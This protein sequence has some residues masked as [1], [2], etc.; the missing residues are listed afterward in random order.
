MPARSVGRRR[1]VV[2]VDAGGA[3]RVDVGGAVGGVG[4]GGAVRVVGGVGARELLCRVAGREVWVVGGAGLVVALVSA[5]EGWWRDAVSVRGGVDARLV[6]L[7]AAG[8]TD[9]VIARELGVGL[10]TVQRRVGDLLARN[11]CRTRFQAGMLL[12]KVD[13]ERARGNAG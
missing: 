6:A 3:V 5:Y 9:K 13:D 4:A 2:A 7:L 12:S 11:G 8:L 10:R 1:E